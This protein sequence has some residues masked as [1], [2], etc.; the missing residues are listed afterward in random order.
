MKGFIKT[1][2][3]EY[4]KEQHNIEFNENFYRWFGDSKI[5]NKEGDPLIVYHGSDI[6]FDSFNVSKMRNGWLSKGFYFTDNKTEAKHYGDK[7]YSVYLRLQNP[8]IIKSD[9]IKDDGTI[10]WA[11]SIKEQLYDIYP[12]LKK[13]DFKN[14]TDILINKG[15]DGIINSNNLISV[16]KPNQI[17]S[18]EN[19]GSWDINDN[20]IYS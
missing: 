20:N 19:D 9:V 3:K 2:L 13:N 15:H 11:K 8:F 18:I 17:K 7:L 6:K 4:I 14:A 5:T 16:F 12:Q 1:T 10:E